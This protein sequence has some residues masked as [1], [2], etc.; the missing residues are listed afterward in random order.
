MSELD[1]LDKILSNETLDDETVVRWRDEINSPNSNLSIT[2]DYLEGTSVT[3]GRL[4]PGGVTVRTFYGEGAYDMAH[5]SLIVCS[6]S[7]RG[8]FLEVRQLPAEMGGKFC[9]V[10]IVEPLSDDSHGNLVLIDLLGEVEVISWEM[11]QQNENRRMT[12]GDMFDFDGIMGDIKNEL[13]P[14]NLGRR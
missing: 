6:P 10:A 13:A 8:R 14:S 11:G 4:L 5:P 1:E 9:S 7:L 12:R 3:A 2:M